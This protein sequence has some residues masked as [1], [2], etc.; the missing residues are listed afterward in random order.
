MVLRAK[1]A[2]IDWRF[3]VNGTIHYLLQSLSNPTTVI[4]TALDS[5]TSQ[6]CNFI[7]TSIFFFQVSHCCVSRIDSGTSVIGNKLKDE[8]QYLILVMH[9]FLVV[10]QNK[11]LR[12]EG[13]YIC[14][15]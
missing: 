9:D 13:C 10:N 8:P 12:S 3:E 2:I 6:H 5:I 4:Q 1:E 15:Y 11:V 14:R 7:S